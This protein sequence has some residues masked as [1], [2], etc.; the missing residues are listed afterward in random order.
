MV[1]SKT[2]A[3]STSL[4]WMKPLLLWHEYQ[5]QWELCFLISNLQRKEPGFPW[6]SRWRKGAIIL[7]TWDTEIRKTAVQGQPGQIV[8][9]TIF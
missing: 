6:L 1:A 8:H 5:W 4:L 7:A 3:L 2:Q 9:E